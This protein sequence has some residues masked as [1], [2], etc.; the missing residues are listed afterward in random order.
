MAKKIEPDI[1]DLN[2]WLT[3][4]EGVA[5]LVQLGVARTSSHLYAKAKNGDFKSRVIKEKLCFWKADIDDY[6]NDLLLKEARR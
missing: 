4:E 3:A 6:A 5:L 1:V 2:A